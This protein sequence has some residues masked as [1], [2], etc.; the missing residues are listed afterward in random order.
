MT[1]AP[2]RVGGHDELTKPDPLAIAQARS[3]GR[4]KGFG[5]RARG[6]AGLHLAIA[7]A[8]TDASRGERVRRGMDGTGVRTAGAKLRQ[9]HMHRNKSIYPTIRSPSPCAIHRSNDE[10]VRMHP[11]LSSIFPSP[12]VRADASE[13]VTRVTSCVLTSLSDRPTLTSIDYETGCFAARKHPKLW[14]AE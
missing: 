9:T 6:K 1:T 12:T 3:H 11:E 5:Q 7:R 14:L 2:G 13:G 4:V 10:R 8:S